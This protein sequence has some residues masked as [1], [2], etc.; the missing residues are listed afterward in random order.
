MDLTITE[1]ESFRVGIPLEAPILT[2]HGSLEGYTR[3][4]VKV[5]TASGLVGLGEASGGVSPDQLVSFGRVLHGWDA[6]DVGRIR[7]RIND[8]GYYIRHERAITAIE[9]ACLD[10]VGKATGRPL[11][12]LLGGKLREQIPAAA[13]LFFRHGHDDHTPVA[14]PEDMARHAIEW[15]DRYG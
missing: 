13:Y 9:L 1:I 5:H 10:V 2:C 8:W 11:Y 14:T 7:A 6:W 4:L 15:R 3:T 12:Q